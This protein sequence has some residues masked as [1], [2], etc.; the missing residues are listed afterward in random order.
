MPGDEPDSRSLATA[1]VARG[2]DDT[3]STASLAVLIALICATLRQVVRTSWLDPAVVDGIRGLAK[4]VGELHAASGGL[5][6]IVDEDAFRHEETGQKFSLA[7]RA[8]VQLHR[9]FQRRGLTAVVFTPPVSAL[10]LK[11]LLR[12]LLDASF[13]VAASLPPRCGLD[14]RRAFAA[15]PSVVILRDG[16]EEPGP[17]GADQD[18]R[19]AA[20]EPR[21]PAGPTEPAASRAGPGQLDRQLQI[22]QREN[23]AIR[24]ACQGLKGAGNEAPDPAILT[25]LEAMERDEHLLYMLASL[26]QHDRYTF[27]HSCNVTLLAVAVAR[28]M[29]FKGDELRRFASAALL[30]DIG[31]L[32]T[33]LAV[34]NKPGKFTPEEWQAMRRHPVDGMEILTG[35]GVENEYSRRVTLL[36]HV[37]FDG[38]GYP[39]NVREEPDIFAHIVQVAD[40]YDA[41]TTIRPYRQQ[42]RPREVLHELRQG[43]GTRYSPVVVDATVKLMGETPM[44][45]VLK[46]DN[47]QLG[48]VVDAGLGE[49]ARPIVRVIQDEFG[50]RPSKTVLLDLGARIPSTGE[51]LVEI[52]EA[53]DPVIRNIQIGRYI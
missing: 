6:L 40:V 52:V 21:A 48:L 3:A 38:K 1:T 26:R 12:G 35:A 43:A 15:A 18:P 24:Q 27:D 44:G 9:F 39:S 17:D 34:L 47:G 28:G 22:I 5:T 33:P 19:P 37:G 23:A 41:F 25:A 31:K 20:D 14:L 32:Y 8:A 46:L 16:S 53:V 45:S 42:V 13:D 10:A 50:N 7:G 30:H 29:G 51:L 2:A 4:L 36:H 49:G 11:N